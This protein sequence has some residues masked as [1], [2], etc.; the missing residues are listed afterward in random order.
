MPA[1]LWLQKLVVFVIKQQC[2]NKKSWRWFFL[3]C[4]YVIQIHSCTFNIKTE[5]TYKLLLFYTSCREKVNITRFYHFTEHLQIQP[6]SLMLMR[7]GLKLQHSTYRG[8]HN[9]ILQTICNQ[10]VHMCYDLGLMHVCSSFRYSLELKGIKSKESHDVPLNVNKIIFD[11]FTKYSKFQ[12]C[13][14]VGIL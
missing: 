9:T 5:V 4:L 7:E 13:S 12:I 3:S 10:G 2:F 6:T 14:W 8:R 1:K 11:G